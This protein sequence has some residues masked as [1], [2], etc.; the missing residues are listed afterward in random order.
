MPH[1]KL[2]SPA[3]ALDIDTHD[4][5]LTL[6]YVV[7]HHLQSGIEPPDWLA[8]YRE[9]LY[10]SSWNDHQKSFF[11]GEDDDFELDQHPKRRQLLAKVLMAA[12]QALATQS[13]DNL[14]T[15]LQTRLELDDMYE[16]IVGNVDDY[17]IQPIANPGELP[18]R[19]Q[20]ILKQV[21]TLLS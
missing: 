15:L 6:R 13:G 5:A 7:I 2:I 10:L 14:I 3:G 4:L 16:G 20:Q 8:D 17:F 9:E 19:I 21:I 12:E 1:T 11:L 18:L